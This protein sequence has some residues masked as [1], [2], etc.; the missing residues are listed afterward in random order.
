MTSQWTGVGEGN[1]EGGG[2]RL[3]DPEVMK[4]S[5]P[6]PGV[7]TTNNDIKRPRLPGP[8]SR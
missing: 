8:V 3:D 2:F 1:K 6:R 5:L 4:V 7:E